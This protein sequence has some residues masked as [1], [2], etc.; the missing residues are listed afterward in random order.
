M[1]NGWRVPTAPWLFPFAIA[2]LAFAGVLVL[3]FTY[4]AATGPVDESAPLPAAAETVRS[5]TTPTLTAAAPPTVT[6]TRAIRTATPSPT[7]T[8]GPN[9]ACRLLSQAEVEAA[10]GMKLQADKGNTA[11]SG[12][13]TYRAVGVTRAVGASVRTF[14]SAGDARRLLAL[15]DWRLVKLSD[16]GVEA[17]A[18][19]DVPGSYTVLLLKGDRAIQLDV[20]DPEHKD[21]LSVAA[22]LAAKVAARM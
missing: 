6:P 3:L 2:A 22:I 9:A 20:F 5:T 13:C 17:Y 21:L 4:T 11:A 12:D 18:I 8:T 1:R 7:P 19:A 14:G 15:K 10:F 16:V